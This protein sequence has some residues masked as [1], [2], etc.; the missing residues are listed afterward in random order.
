MTPVLILVASPSFHVSRG[1]GPT[2]ATA[3]SYG[4]TLYA[5][6][7]SNETYCTPAME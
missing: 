1:T 6:S 4:T 7:I 3:Y 5:M 2:T